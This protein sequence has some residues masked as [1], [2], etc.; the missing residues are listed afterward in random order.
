MFSFQCSVVAPAGPTSMMVRFCTAWACAA[1]FLFG[2]IAEAQDRLHSGRISKSFTEPIQK[3]VAASAEIGVIAIAHVKE[4]DRVRTGDPLAQ[5]SLSDLKETLAIVQASAESTA[6][7]DAASSQVKL[8]KS[9]LQAIESL[10]SGGH[11]N[12]FEVEQKESEYQNAYAEQRAAEDELKLAQLEVDRIKAQV[13]ERLIKSP[14]DGFVTKI[15]KQL[16]ENISNSEPQYATVVRVNELKVRFYLD[17]S[18]LR[19]TQIG[20]IVS[21]EVG[22]ERSRATASVTFISPVIDP[23]SG[24]GRLDVQLDNHDFKIQSGIVCFWGGAR[25][26]L[27]DLSPPENAAQLPMI[28]LAAPS[29]LSR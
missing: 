9:Q 19:D 16:G 15:H 26:A 3:S 17:P 7:L 6:R 2:S 25:K 5:I 10:V 13:E 14:I 22:P 21:I 23:D 20:D 12:R 4:G 18:T 8:I 11:T 28:E 27:R 1:L 29:T 24:L